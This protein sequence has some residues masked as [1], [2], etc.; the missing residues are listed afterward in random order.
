MR[1]LVAACDNR[2]VQV[3]GAEFFYLDKFVALSSGSKVFIY[4]YHL[5]NSKADDIKHVGCVIL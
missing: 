5:D 1:W 4:N 3:N 2:T